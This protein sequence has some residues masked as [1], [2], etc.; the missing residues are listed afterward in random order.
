MAKRILSV[1]FNTPDEDLE[2]VSHNSSASLLDGDIVIFNPDVNEYASYEQYAGQRLISESDSPSLRA[3]ALHWKNEILAL[4]RAGKTVIVM[5]TESPPVY[6]HTGERQF[7]GTGRS[8]QATDFVAPFD[9]YNCLPVNIGSIVRRFGDRIK[10]VGDLRALATYWNIFGPFTNYQIYVEGSSV[11]PLLVTAAGDK[12]VAAVVR[13]KDAPGALVLLPPPD[14]EAATRDRAA[15]LKARARKSKNPASKGSSQSTYVARASK[16]V[17]AEFVQTVIELERVLRS[18]T[19]RTAPPSWTENPAYK[20]QAQVRLEEEIKNIADE[21][22]KLEQ[23]RSA[24]LKQAEDVSG[25]RNLLFEKGK[26]LETSILTAMRLL[27]FSAQPFK[28]GESE[29]DVVLI[30]P[31]GSRFIGEAEGKDDKAIGIE[32]LDQLER[33]IREDFAQREDGAYAGGV[34]FG[35]GFRLTDP[36]ERGDFFSDKCIS[37]A[38]RSGIALVRTPDLFRVAQ[39]LQDHPD[40]AFAKG[41][42]EV[43]TSTKGEIVAFPKAPG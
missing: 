27:G 23:Q 4:L 29:F 37:A 30:A 22:E 42:R 36:S 2:C 11:R 6:Y 10:P 9:P 35:N 25:L 3:N 5:M 20:T 12:L 19:E 16:S 18:D 32:K 7:S 34:L 38:K 1:G 41:C 26:P 24:L 31:E 15:Q 13:I 8:R 28:S 43:L 17:A 39:Y 40:S 21:M 14:F 33:N